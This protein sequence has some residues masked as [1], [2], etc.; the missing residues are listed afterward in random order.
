M[1]K[2][3]LFTL[4]W[5][6]IVPPVDAGGAPLLAALM[7]KVGPWFK[8]CALAYIISMMLIAAWSNDAAAETKFF[9][10]LF[11][12]G[13][14]SVLVSS[15]AAYQYWIV[16]TIQGFIN[17]ISQAIAGTFN[18]GAPI[19]ADSYDAIGIRAFSIGLAVLKNLP[20]FSWKAI[21]L[22]IGVLI[23]WF[24]S[25]GA[26]VVMFSLSLVSRVGFSFLMDWAPV[27]VAFYF[28]HYTRRWFD[29]WL[30]VVMTSALVQIFSTAL[31]GLFIFVIGLI[32]DLAGTGL[33][34]AQSGET[35]GGIVVGSILM[36]AATA[37]IC[38]IFVLIAGAIV[39]FAI[40]ITGGAHTGLG[41]MAAGW[42]PSAPPVPPM[43]SL[44]AP[45]APLS[46]GMPSAP[47]LG[48]GGAPALSPAAQASI[49]QSAMRI[50]GPVT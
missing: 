44:P 45:S 20:M 16:G 24:L 11:L 2:Y 5:N 10:A 46:L 22:G 48:G 12:A 38:N 18:Q 34:T 27:F 3:A 28:V 42:M 49:G 35:D 37:L 25:Y 36:L 47:S 31:A 26:V 39:Y 7:A 29:G 50:V 8:A 1:E 21:P 23:Y 9:K 6:H 43:P 14:I 40:R 41:S 32:F 15:N 19:T 17:G 13:I 30:A 4:L 33:G